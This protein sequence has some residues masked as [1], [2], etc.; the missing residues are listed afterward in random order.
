V[1]SALED[2]GCVYR[3]GDFCL[4][5]DNQLS[6]GMLRIR[7][8]LLTSYS[9]LNVGTDG[10]YVDL[11]ENPERFTGYAGPSANRV[12]KAIYEENC[13]GVVPYVPPSRGKDSGGTGFVTGLEKTDLRSL[14]GNIVAPRD[15]GDEMCLEKRVFYRLVSGASRPSPSINRFCAHASYGK[16]PSCVHIDTHLR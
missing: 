11:Y 10:V 12:W 1:P 3:E 15:R 9:L 4:L 14:M 13:F 7:S 16:R 2:E 8:W 6:D 5:E